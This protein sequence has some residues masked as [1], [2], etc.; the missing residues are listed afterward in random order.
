MNLW[1]VTRARTDQLFNG[2]SQCASSLRTSFIRWLVSIHRG[3]SNRRGFFFVCIRMTGGM[4]LL[5]GS[6]HLKQ[7]S[8]RFWSCAPWWFRVDFGFG[9]FRFDS[10]TFPN[11]V[12]VVFYTSSWVQVRRPEVYGFCLHLGW[13]CDLHGASRSSFDA[14]WFVT[15]EQISWL[16]AAFNV[17]VLWRAGVKDWFPLGK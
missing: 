1:F 6:I 7:V 9:P 3:S 2:C 11:C 13:H 12:S 14:V 10:L 15:R 5:L 16:M 4:K 8:V 17:H